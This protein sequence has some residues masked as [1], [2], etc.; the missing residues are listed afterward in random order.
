L[1]T[2]FLP[3][4]EFAQDIIR[5]H[6][7]KLIQNWNQQERKYSREKRVDIVFK[8]AQ[9]TEYE[10][11]VK[12]IKACQNLRDLFAH[13]KSYTD[14]IESEVLMPNSASDITKVINEPSNF[15]KQ[16]AIDKLKN[17]IE[18]LEEVDKLLGDS[19]GLYWTR[20]FGQ[21]L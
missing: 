12:E 13:G 14:Y 19:S 1:R 21:H 11:Y 4:L 9:I 2:F 15:L 6:G 5:Y 20:D 18:R 16:F 3:N 17:T 7:Y 10:K 8:K